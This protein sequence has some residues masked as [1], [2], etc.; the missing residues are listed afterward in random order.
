VIVSR[1]RFPDGVVSCALFNTP[2]L[3]IFDASTAVE[4]LGRLGYSKSHSWRSGC[5]GK[6]FLGPVARYDPTTAF[7]GFRATANRT[8]APP[9]R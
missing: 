5:A 6:A 8:I 4:L 9:C 1:H 2:G 7:A 3:G